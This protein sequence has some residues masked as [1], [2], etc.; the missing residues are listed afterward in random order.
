M[1]N[2]QYEFDAMV[3]IVCTPQCFPVGLHALDWI[4]LRV[5]FTKKS[6]YMDRG[7]FDDVYGIPPVFFI[8]IVVIHVPLVFRH[9]SVQFT[10]TRSKIW[11][12]ESGEFSKP[13]YVAVC[14]AFGPPDMG[15]DNVE[16]TQ[17][18]LKKT[19]FAR[20]QLS[21]EYVF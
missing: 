7:L 5:P 3:W 18:P 8:R 17:K 15:V 19:K 6:E 21:R 2:P 14:D 10:G 4:D 12:L 1:V 11:L 20:V 9:L 13:A 16:M